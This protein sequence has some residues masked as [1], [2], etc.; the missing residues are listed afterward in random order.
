[1]QTPY[2]VML[3]RANNVLTW[4]NM[5]AAFWPWLTLVGFVVFPST[6]TSFQNSESL[7]NSQSGRLV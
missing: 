3:V 1:M 6:F 7:N 2:M 5:R 4:D